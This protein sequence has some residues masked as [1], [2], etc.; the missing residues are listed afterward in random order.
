MSE[1]RLNIRVDERTKRKA[2]KV[3]Q[4]L[5]LNL[6]AG[7]N[8]Y[9]NRVAAQQAIP[10]PLSLNTSELNEKVLFIETGAQ[11]AVREAIEKQKSE[12]LPVALFDSSLNRPYLEYPDGAKEYAFAK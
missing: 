10:F 4:K 2:E 6:S 9:L 12:G 5:G 3:F 7:I 11:N 8:I 1:S